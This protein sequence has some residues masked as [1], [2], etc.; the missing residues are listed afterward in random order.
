LQQSGEPTK[1]SSRAALLGNFETM[2]RG[3]FLQ[4]ARQQGTRYIIERSEKTKLI[5]GRVI[6]RDD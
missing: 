4:N 3:H 1:L 6:E 2:G 5:E